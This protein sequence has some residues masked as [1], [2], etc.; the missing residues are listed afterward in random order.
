MQGAAPIIP[1]A[2][3]TLDHSP[4]NRSTGRMI[5]SHATRF[6][7]TPAWLPCVSTRLSFATKTCKLAVFAL[8][9]AHSVP[10]A[11]GVKFDAVSARDG[12]W[13]D[14]AT[15]QNGRPPQAGDRVQIR[16]GHAVIYD[17]NSDAAIR[18]VH[19]AGKLSFARDRS[20][21]LD[22]GLIKIEPGDTTTEDGFNCHDT[23]PLGTALAGQTLAALEIGTAE[24]PIPAAVSATIRLV[25]F[26][27][28]NVETLPAI[29]ACG[30][31]W[32]IHGAPLNRT[33]VKLGA[34]AESGATTV[35]LAEPVTGWRV[36]DL[37]IVTVS[38]ENYGSGNTFRQTAAKPRKV[39]TEERRLT[40]IAGAKLTLDRPLDYAHLGTGDYRSEVANLSRNVVVTSAN[41][42]GVRGHTMFHRDS[43]GGISYA[44]FSHL[45]KEGVLGKYAIHFHLVRDTMRGSG[46]TGASIWDSHNR[47]LTIHGTDFLV[48]R[49][50]VGYQSVGHGYFL[51]DAT[52]QYNVLDRNLAV[53]AYKGK[54]LPKQVLPFDA[55]DGAGFWWANG[56]NVFTRN[57]ACENDE[58]GYRYEIAKRSNFSPDLR[59]RLPD[60]TREVRDVRHIPFLRF[61]DN[62]SHSEGLYSFNFGDDVPGSVHGD[63][64]HPF[65]AKNLRAWETHYVIR[66]NLQFFLLDGLVVSNGV[67]G[68]YHPDYDSHVYRNIDFIKVGS[69]PINRGHDDES[70]QYGDF[71]YEHVRLIDCQ[72][73]R[74][75]L[76]QLTCTAPKPGVSGHFRDVSWTGSNR[77]NRKVV[78]LGGGPRNPKLE[79]AVAYYFHDWPT[80]GLQTKVVSV[81]FPEA[82]TGGDFVSVPDFTGKDVRAGRIT[83]VPFPKLLD[84]VDDLA[85]TTVIQSARRA[86]DGRW[87]VRGLAC[88]NGEIATVLV[89]GQRAKILAQHAGVADW[90]ITLPT[91]NPTEI[92]AVA[93]DRAGNA[94]AGGHLVAIRDLQ[95]AQR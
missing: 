82:Q 69:E 4:A 10:A 11:E 5:T 56:R 41:P 38:K 6:Y 23:A 72:A 90:E 48:V 37:I 47:W 21:R 13:S 88:D 16:T 67:Y 42:A 31:R 81:K 70:I 51:E 80:A 1:R 25:H 61:E 65:I 86:A 18:M 75:P 14:T 68:V 77:N 58:Y 60:G 29:I 34:T 89:N 12:K 91:G 78:D 74:D 33:W 24:N 49:D 35:T 93:T 44:E 46:V 71:T 28:M 26:E 73:G 36:G 76:I 27:G 9:A 22:T 79:N 7:S 83:P 19:V 45:G 59:V 52:E 54:R 32:D 94:E 64:Q 15:W 20:T 53:Q 8:L 87:Q 66:P 43:S 95:T 17:A 62:E 40:A 50:N 39:S 92:R 85:P 55:N 30:G 63:K 2:V 57:V 84:P 3:P